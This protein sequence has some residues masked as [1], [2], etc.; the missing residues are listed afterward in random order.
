MKTKCLAIFYFENC[1]RYMKKNKSRDFIFYLI[2]L[3]TVHIKFFLKNLY[4]GFRSKIHNFEFSL[5]KRLGNKNSFL[6]LNQICFF[7]IS[8]FNSK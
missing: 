4:F 8:E 5:T 3:G 7:K 2:K 1:D 6:K